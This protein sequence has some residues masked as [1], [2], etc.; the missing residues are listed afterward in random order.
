MSRIYKN[1]NHGKP[2]DPQIISG[3]KRP[4]TTGSF[5]KVDSHAV[6]DA[7]RPTR[8]GASVK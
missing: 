5:D 8:G 6:R 3:M 2:S 1:P 4:V 7:T